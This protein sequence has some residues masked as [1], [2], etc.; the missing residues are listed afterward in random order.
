MLFAAKAADPA[1]LNTPCLVLPVFEDGRL[2]EPSASLDAQT[3]K[4]FSKLLI[5]GEMSGKLGDTLLLQQIEGLNAQRVLLV[6]AGKQ[7]AFN[8]KKFVKLASAAGKALLK[9]NQLNASV[10]FSGFEI[11]DETPSHLAE[12]CAR[13]LVTQAYRYSTTKKV[14]KVP[15]LQ[16][17]TL[18]TDSAE[19]SAVQHALALGTAI[20]N[21]MNAARQLGNLPANICTPTYLGQEALALGAKH[22]KLL[23][24]KVLSE[25]QMRRLGMS[26]LL[27]VGHGSE[28]DSALIVFE[29]KGA[30]A[31]QKPNVIL[32]KGITFDSGGI[33][34]KPG[35]GMDE[36]KFD[37]CGA[38][39]VFGVIQALCEL[40]PKINVTGVVASAENLPSGRATKPG[41]VITT[42][43]GQTVEVLNTDA[44]GRLVLCDALT[45]IE[46]FFK[47]KSVVD[48]ATLTGACI[49]A[50]GSI[51][52]GLMS[53]DDALADTLYQCGQSALDPCWRL[54]IWDEYQEQLNSNF[55]DIANIGGPKAGTI[56]AACFLSRFAKK[57]KWAH[58]DI[59]GTAW[60][61]GAEKGAT[62]RPVPLLMQYLLNNA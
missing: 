13:T 40:Q 49:T 21:G 45:Y 8:A 61:Q 4:T 2:P 62:G 14:S 43:S 27:S 51:P 54:P 5:S 42:M 57:F 55:A 6:G 37:M 39:S 28:Q 23:K 44:E 25:A 18:L 60:L 1:R 58:L 38:A 3:R 17:I 10:C 7:E 56:T 20:G 50:L 9:H 22:R 36:M 35:A 33:S 24:V 16:Q 48:I 11:K 47:P 59:A 53:N 19:R 41:D 12:L 32:G 30:A 15:E 52:S 26:S 31:T 46:R 34:L 29:Y